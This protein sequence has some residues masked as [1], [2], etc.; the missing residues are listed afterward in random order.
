MVPAS[1]LQ[2]HQKAVYILDREAAGELELADYYK[3]VY[4]HKPDWQKY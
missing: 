3:W 1:I 4:D 2:I